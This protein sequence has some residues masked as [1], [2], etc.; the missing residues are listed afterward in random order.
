MP[1][2]ESVV[3]EKGMYVHCMNNADTDVSFVYDY[4]DGTS[5]YWVL[6]PINRI[7]APT[8]NFG[9]TITQIGINI[10]S[11]KTVDITFSPMFVFSDKAMDFVP[12][13]SVQTLTASTPNSLP[14]IPVSSGGNY[15]DENGQQWICDEIDFARGVYVKRIN[16]GVLDDT[17]AWGERTTTATGKH[18]V[19]A[20]DVILSNISTPFCTHAVF[21]ATEE[22]NWEDGYFTASGKGAFQAYTAMTL[23]EWKTYLN[24]KKSAGAPVV[25]PCNLVTPI[26]T[27][28]TEEELTAYAEL[29]TN[30]PNTT[31]YN[32]ASA[33]M[34]MDYYTPLTAVQMVHSPADEGKVLSIDE[35]GCVILKKIASGDVE[36]DIEEIT[37]IVL[38]ETKKYTDA[39]I[40]EWVG[41]KKVSEQIANA[42]AQKTQ[43]Q[44]ITWGADD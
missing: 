26:E 13:Q 7:S 27:P 9:K 30:K 19:Y 35:H 22:L 8:K 28:L 20:E 17:K 23:A 32:D 31:V 25:V 38:E 34:E 2:E 10:G 24:A 5:S 39:E 41:D 6:S 4:S 12:Y 43:V 29:H 11:G 44:I 1:L 18:Y 3:L 15:T 14:G 36:V 37:N 16:M 40:S 33:Y 42:V 21:S